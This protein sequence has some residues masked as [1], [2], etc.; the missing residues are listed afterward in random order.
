[1]AC[2]TAS[3]EQEVGERWPVASH[4]SAAGSWDQRH[5]GGLVLL[6]QREAWQATQ[7]ALM[8]GKGCSCAVINISICV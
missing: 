8:R 3:G 2:I 4:A 5:W 6:A 7:V 1:M